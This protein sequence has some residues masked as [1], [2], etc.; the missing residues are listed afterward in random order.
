[1]TQR[2]ENCF[3]QAKAQN[4]AILG[5]F[6][7]A[8]D[9]DAETAEMV[10]DTLV[11]NGA[12]FIELGMPFSDPM[13]DGPAI[14][15]SSLRAIKAGMT[16]EKTLKMAGDFR[17]K[18]PHTPL[19]L[20]GYFNPIYIYG[21]DKFLDDAAEAGVDGLIIVDLPP[22]EDSELCDPATAK[23]LD[24]I[25]LVTPT[26][27]GDRLETVLNKAGGFVYYVAIAGITG[28]KSAETD[29]IKTAMQ[30]ISGA[31]ELPAVTGF[32]I[33]T[34]E[35]AGKVAQLGDGVVVG[36]ALVQHIEAASET[37]PLN[38]DKLLQDIGSF[39]AELAQA[40]QR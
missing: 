32:G 30:R 28:T 20:M 34:A 14:Q 5:C 8:G 18:H 13:A 3:A 40:M 1:M 15:A 2:I 21:A 38:R 35:Q 17:A 19:I 37:T 29:S 33:R 25:R 27:L 7:T 6:V 16:L 24:F 39:C 31:T 10:L 26:T 4:R 23:G 9:P 22:E 36:S 11:E 12:D